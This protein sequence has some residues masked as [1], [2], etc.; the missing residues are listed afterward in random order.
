MQM[1]Q[2]VA[3]AVLGVVVL[4]ETLNT[5][6]TGVIA[7]AVVALVMTATIVKLS[8]VE[9]VSTRNRA[10]AKREDRVNQAA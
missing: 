1:S 4:G 7:L 8:S 6:G 10:T 5:G 2:P 3:A 9:A